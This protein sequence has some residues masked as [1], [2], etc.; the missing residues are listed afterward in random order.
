MIDAGADAFIVSGIHH[1]A[2]WDCIRASRFSTASAIS[3]GVICRNRSRPNYTSRAE[4]HA[5][6]ATSFEHPDRA[7]DADLTN[8][9]NAN[10]TFATVGDPTFNRTFQSVIAKTAYDRDTG[11]VSSIRLYPIDLG[12]GEKLTQSGVPRLATG[13]IAGQILDRII[14]LSGKNNG[15]TIRKIVEGG[16]VIGLAEPIR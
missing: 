15:L 11:A 4:I 12:Y 8:I 10:S 14:A 13:P 5:L 2:V 16:H 7:T 3:S 1:V 6:L 9:L